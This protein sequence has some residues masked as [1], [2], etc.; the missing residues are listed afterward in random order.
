MKDGN[1]EFP[2]PAELRERLKA[3]ALAHDLSM[4]QVIRQ[5]LRELFAKT[6]T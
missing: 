2:I 5:A 1:F 3:Y 4:A 6:E